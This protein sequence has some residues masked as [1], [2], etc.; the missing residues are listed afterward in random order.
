MTMTRRRFQ[1]RAG[2]LA[3]FAAASLLPARSL[4][5]PRRPLRILLLGGTQ[6]LGI[7]LAREAI[8]RG[9][10]VTL[11][12]RG[13]TNPQLFPELEKLRGERD[14]QLDALRGREWDCVIDISGLIS[15]HVRLST[16]LLAASTGWYLFV[17]SVDAYASF[18]RPN[19]EDSPLQPLPH[20]EFGPAE[21]IENGPSKVISEYFVRSAYPNRFLILRPTQIVGPLDPAARIASWLVTAMRGGRLPA[22]GTRR[23]PIQFIDARDLARF[24]LD[25]LERNR[26]GIYNV[27]SKPGRFTIG[28]L[29]EACIE[30]ARRGQPA[31]RPVPVWM[32]RDFLES[33]NVATSFPL[34]PGNSAELSLPLIDARRAVSAGLRITRLE[35]TVRDTMR[36]LLE[37]PDPQQQT[38]RAVLSV[39][40]QQALLAAWDSQRRVAQR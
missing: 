8:Q 37:Q 10:R 24:A 32:P 34:W 9:H 15:R 23:D 18:A 25:M 3:G 36:W 19:S 16:E 12:N 2:A 21:K 30:S 20:M 1:L 31:L 22:P 27:A 6:F 33:R 7:H 35:R 28:R 13:V 17:S 5:A 4:G 14:G 29:I 11:F 26:Y 39:E 38:L 40:Q